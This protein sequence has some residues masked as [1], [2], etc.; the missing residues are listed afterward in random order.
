MNYELVYI[1]SPKLSDEEVKKQNQNFIKFLE[2]NG[3]KNIKENFWGK[4]ALAY[5]ISS[6]SDGIY[7]QFNFEIDPAKVQVIDKKLK[8]ID[9]I[10]RYLIV[11]Q[12]E[13]GEIKALREFVKKEESKIEKETKIKATS[14][15]SPKVEKKA[16]GKV[17]LDKKLE[18]LL[19]KDMV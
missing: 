18:E 11:R 12:E 4:K 19:G 14:K 5:E 17:N 15:V 1:L 10:I 2:K 3:A 6:F 16:K 8:L 13:V 9:E 7:T